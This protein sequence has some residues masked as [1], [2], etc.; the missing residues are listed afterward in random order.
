MESFNNTKIEML[1]LHLLENEERFY[2]YNS[3]TLQ[4]FQLCNLKRKNNNF[5]IMGFSY[6]EEQRLKHF[7]N[8]KCN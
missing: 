7:C 2:K 4:K 1:P 6:N 8:L 5:D 3:I